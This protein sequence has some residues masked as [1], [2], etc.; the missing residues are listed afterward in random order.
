MTAQVMKLSMRFEK[1]IAERKCQ[2]AGK[3]QTD[4]DI[5]A[6][7]VQKYNGF[8][9]N[10]ALKR[11]QISPDQHSAILGVICGM[12][13]E[14]RQLVR[15]RLDFNKWEESGFLDIWRLE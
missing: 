6:E 14:A 2:E 8:K 9:A 7:L 5:L 4:A 1:L 15:V 10:A 13:F 3:G 12:T 11:W